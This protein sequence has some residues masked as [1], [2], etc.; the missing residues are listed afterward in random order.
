MGV[1]LNNI[2]VNDPDD[3]IITA[4]NYTN[5]LE[6][7][8]CLIIASKQGMIKRTLV[9]DLGVSKLTKISTVMN[10]DEHDSVCSCAIVANSTN[11]AERIMVISKFGIA[12][13]YLTNQISV[14]SRNAAGVKNITLR[15]ND[16]VAAIFVEE[17]NKEFV[18]LACTQGMKRVRREL[19]PQGNRGNV[20]KSLI[21][22]IKSNPITVLNAFMTNMNETIHVVDIS[23]V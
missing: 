16:E 3:K 23:G 7:S 4:F 19:I 14:I 13:S 2:I 20:G 10:L 6:D 22:Q 11:E 17:A 8:R 5:N 12:L 15:D 18:L 1:H 9:K 21:S